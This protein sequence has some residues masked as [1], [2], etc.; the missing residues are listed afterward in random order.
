MQ[1]QQRNAPCACGSGKKFKYCCDGKNQPDKYLKI[2]ENDNGEE[3]SLIIKNDALNEALHADTVLKNFCKDNFLY[4]FSS[5]LTSNDTNFL[6]KKLKDGT[7]SRN[8]FITAY[9]QNTS[10]E[11]MERVVK[12]CSDELEIFKKRQQII[13]D[14]VGAHH[15]KKYN[16]SVPVF[17]AQLEGLLRD[18]GNLD[19][20]ANIKSTIPTEI[21]GDKLLDFMKIDSHYFRDYIS[22]IFKGN[23]EDGRFNRNSILHGWDLSY[24]TEEQ[25]LI[26]FLLIIEIRMFD[27]FKR[28]PDYKDRFEVKRYDNPFAVGFTFKGRKQ[29]SLSIKYNK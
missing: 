24:G 22:E 5:A 4:F 29:I 25:S 23:P 28:T 13:L 3:L 18:Y 21:W 11:E 7:L 2:Y 20:T 15:Q 26:L 19:R 10:F 9:K 16:L 1:K 17:L 12:G 27:F 14:A 6:H 8:D